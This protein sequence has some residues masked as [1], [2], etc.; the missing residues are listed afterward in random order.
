MG[1]N[2]ESVRIHPSDGSRMSLPFNEKYLVNTDGE[3]EDFHDITVVRVDLTRFDH[4]GDAPLITQDIEQGVLGAEHLKL[5]DEL[6]IIGYPSESN[7]IDYDKGLIQNNR[8]VIRAVYNGESFADH[9]HRI[10][11]ESSIKLEDLDGLSGSP[12]FYMLQRVIDG[13]PVYFPMLV[14]MVLRGTASS[15]IVH[16]VNSSVITRIIKLAEGNN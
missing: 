4:S 16:F 5:S 13:Q 2:I 15:G 9:C 8:V 12:V 14:G 11:I 6:W 3:A 10:K 1:A 7:H